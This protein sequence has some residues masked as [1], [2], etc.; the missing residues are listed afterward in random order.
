[1]HGADKERWRELC[2]QIAVAQDPGKFQKLVSE[3]N[4]LLNK[5]D[6]RINPLHKKDSSTKL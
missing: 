3:L 1:M 6:A 2:E 4:E 5:K